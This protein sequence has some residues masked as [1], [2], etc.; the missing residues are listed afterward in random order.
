VTRPG[1]GRI[2]RPPGDF[3]LWRR[4]VFGMTLG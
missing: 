2:S 3:W 4:G 1:N